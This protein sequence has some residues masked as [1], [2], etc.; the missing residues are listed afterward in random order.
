VSSASLLSIA[1]N[2]GTS[3][4]T[5]SGTTASP[6][7]RSASVALD[8]ADGLIRYSWTANGSATVT[9]TFGFT[10]NSGDDAYAGQVNK[11]GVRVGAAIYSGMATRTFSVVSGDVITISVDTGPG[12]FYQLSFYN[13]SVSA[14]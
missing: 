9:A 6:F 12:A 10:D 13:V 3:T 2:N 4:F 1:R 14:A 5:G 7:T 11:N 8:D